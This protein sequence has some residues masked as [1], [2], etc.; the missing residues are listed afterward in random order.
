M[1]HILNMEEQTTPE[2]KPKTFKDIEISTKTIIGVSNLTL[3]I[4][5]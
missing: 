4:E 3:N 5:E 1:T 2:I